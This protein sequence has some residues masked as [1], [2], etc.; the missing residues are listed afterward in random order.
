VQLQKR[1]H[2]AHRHLLRDPEVEQYQIRRLAVQRAARGPRAARGDVLKPL[3]VDQVFEEVLYVPVVLDHENS[4][5]T[6]VH[7]RSLPALRRE[8]SPETPGEMIRP[9]L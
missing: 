7:G 6:R 2:V 1:H 9:L 5:A 8:P 3:A 4:G